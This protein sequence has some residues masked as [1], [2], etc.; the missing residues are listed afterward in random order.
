MNTE[1][2]KEP[3]TWAK[4]KEF[5]NRLSD[6][7]LE[8]KVQ[9]IQEDGSIDILCASEIGDDHYKFDDEEYSVSKDDFDKDYHL[10]GKYETLEDAIK[11]EEYVMTPKTAVFLYEDF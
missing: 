2:V 11:N 5:C 10:D 9:V 1:E 6:E 7:Q 8:Q 4:L 3:Y